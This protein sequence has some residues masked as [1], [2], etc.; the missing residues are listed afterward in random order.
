[1]TVIYVLGSVASKQNGPRR[2]EASPKPSASDDVFEGGE[3][4]V[5]RRFIRKSGDLFYQPV[6]HHVIC[7]ERQDPLGRDVFQP[8]VPLLCRRVEAALQQ[9]GAGPSPHDVGRRILAVTVHHNDP[10]GPA[11]AL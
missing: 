2:I 5:H 11:Q 6:G 1:M 3:V 4:A 7:I 8:V 10:A 9:V